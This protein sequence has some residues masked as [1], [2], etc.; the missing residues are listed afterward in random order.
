MTYVVITWTKGFQG[1]QL[2]RGVSW[3]MPVIL[4]SAFEYLFGLSPI[5]KLITLLFSLI[6][7]ILDI[8]LIYSSQVLSCPTEQSEVEWKASP[9]VDILIFAMSY[10]YQEFFPYSSIVLFRCDHL[11][12]WSC[13]TWW[14][15]Y[16][17]L[18]SGKTRWVKPRHESLTHKSDRFDRCHVKSINIILPTTSSKLH[19]S[20]SILIHSM[21]SF[22][23]GF[24]FR[25]C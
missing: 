18:T 4:H 8:L 23:V 12:I 10:P 2:A 25:Q 11:F 6:P 24:F 14:H 19:S 17:G 1:T 16:C 3:R 21:L 5:H 13:H 7:A 22:S 9:E 20:I 15:A